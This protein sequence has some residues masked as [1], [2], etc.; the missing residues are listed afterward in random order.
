VAGDF[1]LAVIPTIASYLLP[2]FLKSFSKEFAKVELYVEEMKTGT[3]LSELQSDRLD[4][5][6]LA[7]PIQAKDFKIHP[8][9]Y[10]EFFVYFS[11]GHPLLKKSQISRQELDSGELWLLQDGHCFKDQVLGFCSL[12]S[13][14]EA[15]MANIHFQSGSL[16]TLRRL[17]KSNQG[18]TLIPAMMA[19][20]LDAKEYAAHVRPFKTPSPVR[21]VSFVYRRDH[22]KLEIV[23]AIEDSVRHALPSEIHQKQE[24]NQLVLDF[25]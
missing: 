10:E 25:C 18:Y 23:K 6:I 16:D 1:R 13:G 2:R 21:E 17:V 12:P 4:G 24:K 14:F 7:T 3:I 19:L 8:L 11:G 15:T 22:W 20:S 9:Y 5:A